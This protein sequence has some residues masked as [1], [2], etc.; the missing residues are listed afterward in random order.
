MSRDHG[1]RDMRQDRLWGNRQTVPAWVDALEC[2]IILLEETSLG[3]FIYVK[4]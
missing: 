2:A 1:E 4:E 3:R